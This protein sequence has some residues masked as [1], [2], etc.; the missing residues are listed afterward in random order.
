MQYLFPFGA[1]L[2]GHYDRREMVRFWILSA[3]QLW[4]IGTVVFSVLGWSLG[5]G[6]RAATAGTVFAALLVGAVAAA[7]FVGRRS[8]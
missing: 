5:R 4:L 3:V 2:R 8:E 1:R 7:A 6:I